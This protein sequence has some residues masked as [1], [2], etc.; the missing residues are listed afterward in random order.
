MDNKGI[1]A[2]F[3][4]IAD[5]LEIQGENFFKLNAYR[6]ASLT[7]LGLPKE[8]KDIVAKTPTELSNIPGIGQALKDKIIELVETGN[9]EYHQQLK[10]DFPRGL[11]EILKLRGLGPKKVKLFYEEL[12][13]E[14][15]GALKKAAEEGLL[16]S[17]PKMGEKS[18]SEILKAIAEFSEFS[19]DRILINVAMLEA[20][21][22][23]EYMKQCKDIK[24]IEFAGSLRRAK[25]TIGDIDILLTVENP[26]DSRDKIMKHFVSY[27]EVR[28][29][30][31]EGDTKSS[32]L[33]NSGVDVDLRVVAME[34]FGAAMHYFTGSKNH[35]IKMRDL[36]K[37]K[38]FK[39]NEYGLMKGEELIAGEREEDIF[40]AV[41]LP[42]IPPEMRRNDGEFEYAMKHGE[43]PELV[44]LADIKGDLHCHST[45][46]DGQ[47]SIEQMAEAFIERGYEYFAISDHS[48]LMAVTGGMN[49]ADIEKQWKEVEQLQKQFAGRI[50]ILKGCEVDVLKDGTL[51][52]EDDVLKQ[53]D[54]VIVS[55]H[56]FG[57][58]PAQEQTKRIIRAIENPYSMILANPTG[59]LLNKRPE[60][61]F[62]M[63]A[64]IDA[65]VENKVALEVNSSPRRLDLSEKYLRIARE[66]GAKFVINTDSH[67]TE[68]CHF[69]RYGV[70]MARRGWLT[71]ENIINTRS[72]S[73]LTGY[74]G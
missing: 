51:D 53:L 31:A 66:K 69:M 45:Y 11:L 50:N 60:M 38:G 36:A 1:A 41:G 56:M 33:L 63:E 39:L 58:L 34:S 32:V 23:I 42:Y 3:D 67:S 10:K 26:E 28:N 59:R 73:D 14:T 46:S 61:E 29:I 9:C 68:H 7:I 43:V 48:K 71:K 17:L 27:P 22:Y 74:F 16:R 4:E 25:E 62:D 37:K 2:V 35:N 49:K 65:C 40:A 13:I 5:I 20:E 47:H 21:S 70:G 52:F 30:V 55:A 64:V 57:R 19:S 18:E 44:E 6:R 72:L 24:S 15:V 54:I 12:R 8:L